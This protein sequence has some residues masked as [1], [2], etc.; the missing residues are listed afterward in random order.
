MN[1]KVYI[2]TIVI[3][4]LLFIPACIWNCNILTVLSGIGCSGIAAAIM[5]IFLDM[6]SLKKENDRKVKARAIYFRELK[7]QLK[8]MI[9]R[10]LWFDERMSDDF[11]WSRDPSSYSSLQ[12]MI[13]ASQQYP[14]GEN[15]TF[16]EADA[17]LSV[18]KE[19]YSL[20]QQS[21]LPKDQQ[22]KVQKMFLIIAASGLTL[23]SEVSS[24]KERK[25]ELDT[26]EYLS[27]EEIDNLLFQISLGISLMNNPGKNYGL[28]VESI[29]SAY[30]T[31]CRVGK[32][33]D[34]INIGLHGTIK[35][36]EI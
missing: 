15:I 29:V 18:L 30:K 24:V 27:L 6:A 9:E 8:M 32:Y 23:L 17:R 5:A 34:E 25:L 13:F 19:K 33:S 31:I 16:Q 12:F 26:E 21:C 14:S 3:S 22:Q 35:M 7:E 4:F 11:D 36:N 20:N 1:K 28:A 10:I 2:W